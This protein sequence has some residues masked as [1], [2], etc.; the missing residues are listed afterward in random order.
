MFCLLSWSGCGGILTGI[1]SG[2]STSSTTH[3]DK[4]GALCS[5]DFSEGCCIRLSDPCVS[6]YSFVGSSP[7]ISGLKSGAS[8]CI[9]LPVFM[10]WGGGGEVV[11][12]V[13]LKFYGICCLRVSKVLLSKFVV[14]L[15][16]SGNSR[17]F[18]RSPL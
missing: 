15:A 17:R 3:C 9:M 5:S 8:I 12:V 11:A 7:L 14:N 13:F 2:Q 4:A 16:M 18:C 6:S 10:C 1:V